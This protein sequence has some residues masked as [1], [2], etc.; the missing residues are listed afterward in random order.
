MIINERQQAMSIKGRAIEFVVILIAFRLLFQRAA[1]FARRKFDANGSHSWPKK[2]F[3]GVIHIG[4]SS[5]KSVTVAESHQKLLSLVVGVHRDSQKDL[6]TA[7]GGAGEGLVTDFV[8][9]NLHILGGVRFKN[10]K[11]TRFIRP[12]DLAV[13]QYPGGAHRTSQPLL[14]FFFPR[15]AIP[16][17]EHA[18]IGQ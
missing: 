7:D 10:P 5:I 2:P 16:T 12:I 8:F 4:S 14:P 3:G 1:F 17:I 6:A 15:L 11:L 9:G 13:K 18:A